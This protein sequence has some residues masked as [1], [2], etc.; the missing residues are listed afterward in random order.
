MLQ[1]VVSI[2]AFDEKSLSYDLTLEVQLYSSFLTPN[3]NF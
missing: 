3:Y 2:V 1:L